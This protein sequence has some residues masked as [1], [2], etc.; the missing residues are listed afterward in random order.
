MSSASALNSV[1][2]ALGLRITEGPHAKETFTVNKT[3]FTIGRGAENDII[4]PN[5]PK[6]SRKHIKVRFE[7]DSVYVENLSARNPLL[8]K[9]QVEQRVELRPNEKIRVG[10]TE[11]EFSWQAQPGEKTVHA[12]AETLALLAKEQN[13]VDSE[14]SQSSV[15]IV[16]AF[17]NQDSSAFGFKQ[18]KTL[19]LNN[20][21]EK[22]ITQLKGLGISS[23]KSV[24]E[25]RYTP[26]SGGVGG[27]SKGD[28]VVGE[29]ASN[30]ARSSLVTSRNSMGGPVV[31]GLIAVV[32]IVGIVFFADDGQKN[33]KVTPLKSMEQIN[34]ELRESTDVVE[35]YKKEKRI[36]E[37]GRMDR[38]YE[39]AQAYYIKGFRDYRQGQYARA[40]MS[41]QAALSFDPGHILA[42]KYLNQSI[43]KHSELVQFNLDQARRYRKKNNFRLCR[44]SAQQV[45]THRKD[46]TDQQYKDAK[47]LFEECDTLSKGRF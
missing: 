1:P 24:P 30:R 11:I 29:A 19:A 45:M 33:K 25:V 44:A 36:L 22:K 32:F 31:I 5:D 6:L 14:S 35:Q 7:N 9:G 42:R 16:S 3:S 41:L 20:N 21:N 40:I 34:A 13:R 18:D 47:V 39:S 27:F 43:K 12:G 46:Q 37:D 2:A 10:D 23:K 4:L 8:F 15:P 28:S 17:D 26:T 38:Q